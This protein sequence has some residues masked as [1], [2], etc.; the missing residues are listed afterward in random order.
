[1]RT[2]FMFI[3]I[4]A[5]A[6]IPFAS[7]K[8][9]FYSALESKASVEAEGGTVV[10]GKFEPGKFGNGWIGE[11]ESD[12]ITFPTED[13][14]NLEAGT[15]ELWV[16]VGW[17]AA[18]MPNFIGEKERF[19]F[20]SYLRP[21]DAFYFQ[22]DGRASSESATLAMRIKSAGTWYDAYSKELDWKKGEIHHAAGTWG[23][24]GIKLY[25]D[26]ELAGT[27]N[28]QGGPTALAEAF[29]VGSNEKAEFLTGYVVDEFR[30]SDH[31]KKPDEFIMSEEAISAEGKLAATWGGIKNMY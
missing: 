6:C 29:T 11:K 28:F 27:N 10:G 20:A 12:K 7:A 26:G 4:I 19:L 9:T 13:V 31:Q 15:V 3:V 2:L 30:L 22:F 21:T 25:L 1:M 17:D 5:L 14:L 8:E 18:E 23:Q 24:D 16:K